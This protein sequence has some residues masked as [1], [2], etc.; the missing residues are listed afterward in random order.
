MSFNG[1]YFVVRQFFPQMD[2]GASDED[3]ECTVRIEDSL[4]RAAGSFKGSG[5]YGCPNAR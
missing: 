1:G 5:A 3:D 2:P 4:Q